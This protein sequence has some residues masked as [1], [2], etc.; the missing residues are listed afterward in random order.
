VTSIPAF[1]ISSGEKTERINSIQE[2]LSRLRI[3]I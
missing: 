1:F 2:V 3:A